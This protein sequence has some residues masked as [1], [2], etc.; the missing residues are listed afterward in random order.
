MHNPGMKAI[1]VYDR[2]CMLPIQ[3]NVGRQGFLDT[4]MYHVGTEARTFM[5]YGPLKL[6]TRLL[7]L[8]L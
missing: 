5:F 1:I 4:G 3:V 7:A 2:N 8:Y 6:G